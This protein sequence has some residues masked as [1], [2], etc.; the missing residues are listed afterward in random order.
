[1]R[2]HPP[3]QD[4]AS[5]S[6][7][8]IVSSNPTP[9]PNNR[10]T[11]SSNSCQSRLELWLTEALGT[12]E[13]RPPSVHCLLAYLHTPVL[14]EERIENEASICKGDEEEIHSK[15]EEEEVMDPPPRKERKLAHS[16]EDDTHDSQKIEK[17]SST[18]EDVIVD[19]RKLTLPEV[20]CNPGITSS[21]KTLAAIV[22]L[23]LVWEA[24]GIPKEEDAP[25]NDDDSILSVGDLQEDDAG[26]RSQP[27]P[28]T[29]PRG[30]SCNTASKQLSK[31]QVVLDVE[32]LLLPKSC[33][34]VLQQEDKDNEN[35]ISK[36]KELLQQRL[37]ERIWLR[38]AL[39]SKLIQC[40]SIRSRDCSN[41]TPNADGKEDPPVDSA[42][43]PAA[44]LVPSAE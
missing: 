3:Q 24:S 30:L 31:S 23:N 40:H 32:H 1:M 41:R 39:L 13:D 28:R 2:T 26:P 37:Q 6:N 20:S 36:E 33:D 14:E 11:T 35:A 29:S 25:A 5:T 38:L 15:K 21:K 44:V 18:K 10:Q 42:Q 43:K 27:P 12:D 4:T 7:P 16:N 17:A 22:F 19:E 9:P 8:V 34:D